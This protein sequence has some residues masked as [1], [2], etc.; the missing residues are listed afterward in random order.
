MPSTGSQKQSRLISALFETLLVLNAAR[1][2]VLV[3]GGNLDYDAR[4]NDQCRHR[5][6]KSTF[7]VCENED[8]NAH[9][10]IDSGPEIRLFH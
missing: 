6:R 5:F 4:F 1:C 8:N 9:S 3:S 2:A 10:D 7:L